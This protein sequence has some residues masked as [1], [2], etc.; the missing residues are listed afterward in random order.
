MPIIDNINPTQAVEC[1]LCGVRFERKIKSDKFFIGSG[2][3]EVGIWIA[4][5]VGPV[6]SMNSHGSIRVDYAC[7]D[8]RISF[9]EQVRSLIEG[10]RRDKAA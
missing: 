3:E 7:E 1:D 2:W 9:V 4:P 6:D 8:C 5:N 10:M